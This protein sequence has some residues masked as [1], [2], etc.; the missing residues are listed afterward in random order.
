MCH[1]ATIVLHAFDLMGLSFVS[2]REAGVT[3]S[4]LLNFAITDGET[5]IAYVVYS[6]VPMSFVLA[7]VGVCVYVCTKR[8]TDLIDMNPR[9]PC[10]TRIVFGSGG[11]ASLYFSSGSAWEEAASEPGVYR[12]VQ[13]QRARSRE[14]ICLSL[15]AHFPFPALLLLVCLPSP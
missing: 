13:V 15:A 8:L 9:H 11:A 2:F 5:V 1:S 6:Y 14:V 12:M 4:S 3:E 10:R 7:C